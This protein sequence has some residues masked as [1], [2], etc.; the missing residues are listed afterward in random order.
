MGLKG[1][2]V[3]EDNNEWDGKAVMYLK[4]IISGVERQVRIY[5]EK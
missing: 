2:Y 5:R 1:S 3:F 4:R